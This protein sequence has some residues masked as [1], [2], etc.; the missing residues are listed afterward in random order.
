MAFIES[1]R[2]DDIQVSMVDYSFVVPLVGMLREG[3][4]QVQCSLFSTVKEL[5][6]YGKSCE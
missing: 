2:K 1:Y 5:V 3:D 6:R 4:H